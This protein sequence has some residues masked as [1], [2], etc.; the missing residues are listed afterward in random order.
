MSLGWFATFLKALAT[1][2]DEEEEEE[3]EEDE[4]EEE[5]LNAESAVVVREVKTDRG[6][7]AAGPSNPTPTFIPPPSLDVIGC[8]VEMILSAPPTGRLFC[9]CSSLLLISSS[10]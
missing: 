3:K 8:L 2:V 4:V 1:E 5:E 10:D 7:I 6:G 9:I